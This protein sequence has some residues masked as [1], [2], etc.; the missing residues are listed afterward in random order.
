MTPVLPVLPVL[1]LAA[2]CETTFAL[3]LFFAV[4]LFK[5]VTQ[6]SIRSNPPHR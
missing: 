2:D 4:V 6:A 3:A 5:A 1:L